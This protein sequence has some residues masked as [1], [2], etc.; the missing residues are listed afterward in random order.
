MTKEYPLNLKRHCKEVT[1][2]VNDLFNFF[3][4]LYTRNTRYR[5]QTDTYGITVYSIIS[6]DNKIREIRS[7]INNKLKKMLYYTHRNTQ[8]FIKTIMDRGL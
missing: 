4:F 7:Y 6:R 8:I 1:T 3:K 2:I 5:S